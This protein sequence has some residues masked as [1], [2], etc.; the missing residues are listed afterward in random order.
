MKFTLKSNFQPSGDQPEAIKSLEEGI[1][2]GV[3]DQVLLGVTGSGKSLSFDE[4]IYIET[5]EETK[6][7]PI[8]KII[9]E[10]MEK[11]DYTV[12]QDTDMLDRDRITQ[13]YSTIGINSTTGKIEKKPITQFTRHASPKE[14]F[15][16][17]TSCGKNVTTTGD[18]NFWILRDGKLIL[19]K[20]MGIR[21]T[22]Y[23][24]IP[25]V[26]EPNHIERL[27]S[28]N[29]LPL[30]DPTQAYC[31]YSEVNKL[32]KI[33]NTYLKDKLGYQKYYHIVNSDE[34]ISLDDLYKLAGESKYKDFSVYSFNGTSLRSN[35]QIS[36]ELLSLIGIYIAEGHSE[37]K[38]LLISAHEKEMK[39]LLIKWLCDLSIE[40]KERNFNP[41]DFQISHS[42]LSQVFTS[43]CGH[44]S[45][46]KQL[47]QWFLDLDNSQLAV[48]L[49]S[50]MSGDGTVTD[51]EVSTVTASKQLSSEL[52]YAFL[53]YGIHTRIRTKL[54]AATN[55][56]KKIKRIYY[57]VVISG[58]HDLKIYRDQVGFALKRKQAKLSTII[59]KQYNTNTDIVPIDG[60]DLATLRVRHRITQKE[61]GTKIGV[62][63]SYISMVEH[64]LRKLS[65]DKYSLLLNA[66]PGETWL[67]FYK[68]SFWTKIKNVTKIPTT[69]K[70]VYEWQ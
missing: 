53:R 13:K 23:L 59:H 44:D 22:D 40:Y 34:S 14:L 20:P 64:N 24:P 55:T 17:F 6:L 15:K 54:K 30:L 33:T 66:F 47:P 5:G 10:L 29:V 60:N 45:R 49:S 69:S 8:G 43:W 36:N 35:L 26:I 18:H 41:G 39:D 27:S 68:N 58:Q 3:R 1:K 4:P 50:Y 28:I 9:D 52:T 61:F 38:Y 25:R 7:L 16:V 21:N 57:E 70:Y 62:N 2:S 37:D 51:N 31:K 56:I 65:Y 42:V 11:N 46:S 63:R 48:L 67:N 19:I 32:L 12:S